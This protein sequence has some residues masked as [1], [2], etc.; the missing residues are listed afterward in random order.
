MPGMIVD[1]ATYRDGHRVEGPED[2]SDALEAVRAAG[3]GFLWIG[4]HDPSV[5]EL[6]LVA[7]EF[8][9]HPLAV[10]DALTAAHQRP[11]LEV[12]P[13]SVFA[14]V[15]TLAYE[16]PDVPVV[17]GEVLM[18][19]GDAF[20]ITVRHGAISPL[21]TLRKDLEGRPEILALGPAAV[22]YGVCDRVVDDYVDLVTTVQ[23]D[24]DELEAEVFA[25]GRTRGVAERIYSFKRQAVAFRRAVAPLQEPAARLVRG[26]LPFV[27]EDLQAYLRDVLDHLTRVNEQIDA[28]D[29][30]L[31]DILA[32][33]LAQVSVQQNNDMRK[34]SA[35]AA[36]AAVPT[37][38]AG[39]YGM[40]FE[41]MPELR[42]PWGYP[43][44]VGLMALAC[45]VLYRSFKRAGWL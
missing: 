18:F 22:L 39:I 32:A 44:A 27:P 5:E 3:D 45:A 36:L 13:D 40:N 31:T 2:F 41:H 9:L 16:R 34:I 20:V 6:D 26:G 33:N 15:K 25:P 43:A 19:V 8:D 10:E 37:M 29:R 28:L 38:I 35:W 30:L 17:T 11:K 4:L 14:V 1:C 7:A 23:G 12:Y 24:L 42:Q 21:G